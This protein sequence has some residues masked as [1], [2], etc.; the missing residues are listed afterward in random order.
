[1]STQTVSTMTLR[2]AFDGPAGAVACADEMPLNMIP[3]SGR[4]IHL[5]TVVIFVF[6]MI[7]L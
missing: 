7:L 5:E 3:S 2:S 1:M 6:V 4:D